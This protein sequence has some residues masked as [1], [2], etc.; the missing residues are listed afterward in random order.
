MIRDAG[1]TQVHIFY[2][3]TVQGVGFRFTT[4]ELASGLGLNG[5]VRNLSDGRVEILVEGRQSVIEQL[6]QELDGH[7]KGYIKNKEIDFSP[8]QS[9]FKDFRIV[10]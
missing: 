4:Q 10:R 2:S 5:W 6:I 3:G 7:F 9:Q 1:M 8:H